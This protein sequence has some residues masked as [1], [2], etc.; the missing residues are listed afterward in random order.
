MPP[1]RPETTENAKNTGPDPCRW[2]LPQPPPPRLL[3]CSSLPERVGFDNMIPA[4]GPVGT[5]KRT[6]GVYG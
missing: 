4:P 3:A 1:G 2:A 6:G 5:E